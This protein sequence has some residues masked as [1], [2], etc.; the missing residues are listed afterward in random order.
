[1]EP[2]RRIVAF[3]SFALVARQFNAKCLVNSRYST[4]ESSTKLTAI[5]K[6]A[7]LPYTARGF[8]GLAMDGAWA[9][10][11]RRA[12]GPIL[13]SEQIPAG[14][15]S[16]QAAATAG[17]NPRS[18]Q[19]SSAGGPTTASPGLSLTAWISRPQR[20]LFWAPL[21]YSS[22]RHWT[23]VG[24]D[25]RAAMCSGSTP[26]VVVQQGRRDVREGLID[27]VVGD[28]PA[29]TSHASVVLGLILVA[30]A[31]EFDVA[32]VACNR[33]CRRRSN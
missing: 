29:W 18:S 30:I 32:I 23:I 25:P 7:T 17:Q 26:S 20:P 31:V 1:M 9:S 12:P 2:T 19:A 14:G 13:T 27:D 10:S 15:A 3:G 8:Y 21:G 33:R 24:G 11:K 4:F 6:V 16:A 28:A 5:R 22:T